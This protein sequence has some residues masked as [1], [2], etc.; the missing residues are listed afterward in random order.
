MKKVVL[1]CFIALLGC[2]LKAQYDFSPI[3]QLIT[4]SINVIGQSGQNCGFM[5]VQGDSVIYEQYWGTWNSNTYQPIASGSKMPS[6]ALIMRLID[7]GYLSPNDTVQ[8]FLPSFNA[9]PVITLHQLMN[10]TSGLPGNS[11][12]ISNNTLTLQQAVDSIGLNTPMTSY[13]PGT[14]FQYGGVSMHVAGRMAEIATGMRW[15]T[16]FQQ[17]I[18]IPLGMT[19]TDYLALG[20]TTNYRIAGG[21]GTTMSDFSKILIMLLNYGKFNNVQIIDSLTV[22]MMQSDQTNGVPL[23]S[24]PYSGDPLRQNFRYGY[25]V[26]VEQ[27][28]NGE[29]TQ[30]GSQGAFGFTPWIDRCRNIACLL[31]VRK[32]LNAIQPTHTQLR[33]LV[34]QIIPIKLQKPVITLNGNQLQSSYQYGNQWYF[35]GTILTGETNQF[36]NPTQSGN[37][38]V[39]YTSEEGCEIFSDDFHYTVLSVTEH[40]NQAILSIFPNPANTIIYVDCKKGFQ[41]YNSTGQLVKHSSQATTQINISDLPTGLYILKTENQQERFVKTE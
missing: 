2:D 35:N 28:T 4:D 17:K 26:W 15:D 5:I 36:I 25:G 9:K 18:A 16:L 3:T 23:I 30:Y 33:N 29:T 32:S 20:A 34:E 38:S 27:E 19:N 1:V 41:I 24:T 13:A 12:Y 14:A 8:N 40:P 21:M 6:M 7:E 37:Y 31:F 39:K 11:N 22:K 10:H